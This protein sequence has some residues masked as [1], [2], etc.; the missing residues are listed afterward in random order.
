MKTDTII[1]CSNHNNARAAWE[2][3]KCGKSLCPSCAAPDHVDNMGDVIRCIHCGGIAK[4]IMVERQVEPWWKKLPLFLKAIFSLRGIGELFIVAIFLVITGFMS[5]VPLIGFIFKYSL[6]Y[7]ILAS[8]LF[9][10]LQHATD[11]NDDLPALTDMGRDLSEI[12]VAALRIILSTALVWVPLI[13]YVITKH[14]TITVDGLYSDP[15]ILAI[16]IIGVIFVPA[17][18]ILAA[19]TDSAIDA[20]NPV[21]VFGVIMRAPGQYLGVAIFSGALFFGKVVL[22][23]LI[24]LFALKIAGTSFLLVLLT[25][26]VIMAIML[27]FP[28]LMAMVLGWFVHQNAELFDLPPG[29]QMVAVMPRARPLANLAEKKIKEE[30]QE[31]VQSFPDAL[32][33][34]ST[35]EEALVG[36]LKMGNDSIA[37]ESYRKINEQGRVPDLE[38]EQE[39]QL[40]PI[41]ER[42]GDLKGAVH[43]YRRAVKKDLQGPLA[44]KAL[45]HAARILHDGLGAKEDA[46]KL[47][48]FLLEKFPTDGLAQQAQRFL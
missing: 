34:E 29:G 41:L 36:S 25:A 21:N 45:F 24:L 10:V 12:L 39:I 15:V 28:T 48:K 31:P 6:Y 35:P 30:S 8:F 11:G 17:A 27:M 23:P 9:L 44:S 22:Q 42:A 32:E 18:F 43:S 40:A 26:P 38:V 20:L 1:R 19:L 37:L 4:A 33:L 14:A 16:G 5:I 46:K 3:T 2:C 7:G 13:I 47:A